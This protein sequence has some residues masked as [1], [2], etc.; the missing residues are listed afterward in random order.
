MSATCAFFLDSVTLELPVE[1]M[2]ATATGLYHVFL[3]QT[4]TGL[5]NVVDSATL[6]ATGLYNVNINSLGMTGLY[7][8]NHPIPAYILVNVFSPSTTNSWY[9]NT[10]GTS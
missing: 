6:P 10:G 2:Y 8:V 9:S 3:S 1:P 4:A 7:N 5:Y